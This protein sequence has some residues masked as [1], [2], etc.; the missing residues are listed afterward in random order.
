MPCQIRGFWKSKEYH[1]QKLQ[2]TISVS[3]VLLLSCTED[4]IGGGEGTESY[5]YSNKCVNRNCK[6]TRKRK[7]FS[8][9]LAAF[10][11]GEWVNWVILTSRKISSTRIGKASCTQKVQSAHFKQLTEFCQ[12]IYNCFKLFIPISWALIQCLL[13]YDTIMQT[14]IKRFLEW[15][16]RWKKMPCPPCPPPMIQEFPYPFCFQ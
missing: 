7:D 3:Q 1:K 9:W 14:A 13:K 8:R 6:R 10:W 11:W 16:M 2:E 15:S 5:F 12:W 4:I